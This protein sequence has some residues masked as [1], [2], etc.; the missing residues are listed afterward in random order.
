[1][2][3]L[4]KRSISSGRS[5]FAAS[6]I[7]SQ[8]GSFAGFLQ[9]GGNLALFPDLCVDQRIAGGF[10]GL[11]HVRTRVQHQA[12]GGGAF[13]HDRADQ[14]RL[15]ELVVVVGQGIVDVLHRAEVFQNLGRVVGEDRLVKCERRFPC[16]RRFLRI[17]RGRGGVLRGFGLAFGLVRIQE[18]DRLVL[19]VR[20]HVFREDRRL[21]L[22]LFVGENELQVVDAVLFAQDLHG[23]LPSN[24]G[25]LQSAP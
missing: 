21:E 23:R 15:L 8:T 19:L 18:Q 12:H 5:C 16:V 9:H 2:A 4:K 11:V 6:S 22:D 25:R 10:V 7:V 1:M 13:E 17:L 3:S 24:P 20:A 14:R